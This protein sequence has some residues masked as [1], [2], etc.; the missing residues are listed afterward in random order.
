[1]PFEQGFG[2]GCGLELKSA[3]AQ[4]IVTGNWFGM[5]MRYR[6][7]SLWRFLERRTVA[8]G[9]LLMAVCGQS[10]AAERIGS[11]MLAILPKYCPHT[12]GFSS[13][14][15]SSRDD[16]KYWVDLIGPGFE[17]MQHHCYGLI[18]LHEATRAKSRTQRQH[19]YRMAVNEFEYVISRVGSDFVL[20]PEVQTR[21]SDALAKLGDYV[22]AEA[23]YRRVVEIKSDYW[24]AYKGLAESL[25]AR[26]QVS[27]ARE[28]L[29]DA[30]GKVSDQRSL[31]KMLDELENTK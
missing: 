7:F 25:V 10:G 13:Q 16:A 14:L 11:E 30:L 31:K 28:L 9:L 29:N 24:P 2:S 1:M 3:V 26:K 20:L 8:C 27:A 23:G 17:T 12:S 19:H 6:S 22:R 4:T 18:Q 21:Q 5:G 15:A